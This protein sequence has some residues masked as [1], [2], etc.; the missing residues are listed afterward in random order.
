VSQ[1]ITTTPLLDMRPVGSP[2]ERSLPRLE[3]IL[4]REFK[5]RVT[6]RLAEPIER[7]DGAGIDWYIDNENDEGLMRLKDLPEDLATYYKKRLEADVATIG[8]AAQ[9]YETRTDQA[10][11][12]T[13][14]ALRNAICYP[15]D[16]H[17]W[18]IGDTRSGKACVVVTAWGYEQRTSELTGNHAI[19]RRERFFPDSAQVMI[20]QPPP[21]AETVPVKT[22]LVERPGNW[23]RMLTA[24]LWVIAIVLPFVIGWLLLPACGL[25]VPFT[26]TV[27]YGWGDGAFCRQVPNPQLELSGSRVETARAELDSLKDDVVTKI[28]RCAPVAEAAT[29]RDED[30]IEAEGLDVDPDETSVSL[31]W[32]NTNDLDLFIGCPDGS[33]V[34]LN[35][36]RCGFRHQIDKNDGVHGPS[37]TNPVEYIRAEQQTLPPGTYKVIVRYYKNNPP[38]GVATDFT[39]AVRRNGEKKEFSTRTS[40][41]VPTTGEKEQIP[42]TEFTIP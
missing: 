3:A 9:S 16:E 36:A 29:P 32:N 35:G 20:D 33:E 31:T 17:L 4:S 30:L 26:Q 2:A 34:P 25:R 41:V 22:V 1:F 18:V 5:N 28:F 11:K 42:I 24:A 40:D 21:T 7:R 6:M 39:V 37:V 13:A 19:H 8:G 15:G 23:L 14:A 12:S 27:V 10:A 38:S